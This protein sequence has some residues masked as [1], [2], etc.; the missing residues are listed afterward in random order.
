MP[1]YLFTFTDIFLALS[2]PLLVSTLS[3]SSLLA[4]NHVFNLLSISANVGK[5]SLR[6]FNFPE[7][8]FVIAPLSTALATR[9]SISSFGVPA[10]SK[11]NLN[12]LLGSLLNEADYFNFIED[13]QPFVYKSIKEMLC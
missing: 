11:A 1:F 8:D 13:D 6:T 4:S 7:L 10:R 3:I 12:A 5:S 9:I 2:N